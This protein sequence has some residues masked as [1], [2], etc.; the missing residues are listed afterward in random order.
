[1][2]VMKNIRYHSL[3][4]W[5]TNSQYVFSIIV[6]CELEWWMMVVGIYQQW[7]VAQILWLEANCISAMRVRC[8][9][10]WFCQFCTHMETEAEK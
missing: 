8:A 5:D 4:S 2:E 9:L 6:M 10:N 7:H 3:S 1:M